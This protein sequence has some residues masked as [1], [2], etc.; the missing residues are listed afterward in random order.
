MRKLQINLIKDKRRE[1]K[2][3][4]VRWWGE[5]DPK[6]GKQKRY[7]KSFSRK[8]DA[9][10]LVDEKKGDFEAGMSIDHENTTL[11]QMCD[12]F[13]K[14]KKTPLSY[15]SLYGYQETIL[16]LTEYF[17]PNTPL[18]NIQAVH[19]EEFISNLTIVNKDHLKKNKPL[20]DSARSKHLRQ[21]KAIFNTALKWGFIRTNPFNGISLGEIR[22]QPWHYITPEEF[23]ALLQAV[24]NMR[25]RTKDKRQDE[26]KKSD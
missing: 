8:K 1:D 2:P 9:E 10:R 20:S 11:A 6:T 14:A 17:Y 19:A 24:D 5:Y 15:A 13:I 4:I 22:K 7:S 12:S 23:K 16:R 18:R 25:T 3:W 26:V 21:A